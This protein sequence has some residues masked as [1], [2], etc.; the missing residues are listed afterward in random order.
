[1]NGTSPGIVVTVQNNSGGGGGGGSIDVTPP[2]IPTH[3][4]ALP[5]SQNE[6][7][8]SWTASTDNFGVVGYR[9]YRNGAMIVMTP[10]THYND[11]TLKPSTSYSYTVAA[12][13]AAANV[14]AQSS[15]A[16]ATTVGA[17]QAPTD[18]RFGRNILI[19]NTV[20]FL[21]PSGSKRPYTSAGGFLSFGFNSFSTVLTPNQD[22]QNLPTGSF[23]Y[24]MDGSLI[25]DHGTVYVIT[26]GKRAGFTKASIFL[27]L[28]YKWA[29]VLEGDTSFMETLLPISS[30][31]Q[32]HVPDTL[33]NDHGTIY[34]LGTTGKLGIPSP[35]V[36]NSW[37]YSFGKAVLANAFDHPILQVGVMSPRAA[38]ELSPY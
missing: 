36:F 22:E 34:L 16:S 21:D 14:S 10:L 6:I 25:N 13:D 15:P 26:Q 2:S 29:N 30:I 9:V 20:Y 33:I 38:G 17:A 19:G 4:S 32:A 1:M 11:L 35:A 12:Y 7:D 5:V 31:A 8:L 3:L 18:I 37:G 24:P 28:G 27:G 23:V